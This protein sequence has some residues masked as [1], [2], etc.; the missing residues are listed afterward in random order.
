LKRDDFF[1]QNLFIIIILINNK[2]NNPESRTTYE[3]HLDDVQYE[4]LNNEL[5]GLC[6]W[7]ENCYVWC[8]KY[9]TWIK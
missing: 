8:T 7:Y 3:Y 4:I 2:K 1:I 6:F 9:W 5:K